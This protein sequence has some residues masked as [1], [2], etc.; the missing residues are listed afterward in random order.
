M[1]E[2]VIEMWTCGEGVMHSAFVCISI[3]FLQLFLY[4]LC[5]KHETRSD[6]V[7]RIPLQGIELESFCS[8]SDLSIFAGDLIRFP[9]LGS[10]LEYLCSGLDLS[11]FT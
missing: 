10:D 9:L 2:E 5:L 6:C 3:W 4:S 7:I 11:T 8:G 1:E